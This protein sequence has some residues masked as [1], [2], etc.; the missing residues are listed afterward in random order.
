MSKLSRRSLVSSAAAL[1]AL[2]VPAVA[3][4]LPAGADIE[5]QQLGVRLL[6]INR[7]LASLEADPNSYRW[8]RNRS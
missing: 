4:A 2:A 8:I 6:A 3:S 1:P 5:L 7:R